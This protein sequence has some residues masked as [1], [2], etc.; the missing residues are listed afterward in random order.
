MLF[1]PDTPRWYYARN[2]L[3][4]GDAV[5][6]QLNDLPIDSIKVQDTRREI[7]NAIE[8]ELEAE[9]SLHWKQFLTLGVIDRTPM[10][11]IRRIMICFWLP[12]IREWMGSSLM[13]YY[14]EFQTRSADRW[15]LLFRN[16]LTPK[17][18]FSPRFGH[19]ARSRRPPITYLPPLRCSEY[20]LRARLLPTHLHHRAC[21]TSLS[22]DVRRNGHVCPDVNLH[23]FTSSATHPVN[24]VGRHWHNLHLRKSAKTK[25]LKDNLEIEPSLISSSLHLQLF[26]FGYAWQ[27]CVWLYCSEIAPLEY[28]HIGGAATAFGEWLMT[29]IT[30][31]A[32]PIGLANIGWKFWLWILSGNLVAI[33]F[34]YFLCP[35]TG[36]K[37]L[38]D[39]DFL[40]G[41]EKAVSQ[42]MASEDMEG[43]WE[44]KKTS[45]VTRT[46]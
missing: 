35:E 18:D 24:P 5:L 21:R 8:A 30:V 25:Y 34:V 37:T 23:S 16:S 29:F 32:G 12:M 45:A 39:V 14:S 7:M 36:G 33:V 11:I 4:E 3:E 1:L 10:K 42:G 28:R 46:K 20:I 27:G 41:G 26:V 31:F 17:S 13:A 44:E 2:R 40:F 38:E 9:S 22:T 19:S 15:L 43:G 6:S